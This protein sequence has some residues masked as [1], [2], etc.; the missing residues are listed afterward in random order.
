MTE[1][2]G[3]PPVDPTERLVQPP[4]HVV[5]PR[6]INI[7]ESYIQVYQHLISFAGEQSC[8]YRSILSKM[9]E[10]YSTHI[11]DILR[12]YVRQ[13]QFILI[14]L[15]LFSLQSAVPRCDLDLQSFGRLAKNVSGFDSQNSSTDQK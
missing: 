11:F 5:K 2:V 3:D 10:F 9:N 14:N 1:A 7:T 13:F 6:D 4:S 8:D 15:K 12:D